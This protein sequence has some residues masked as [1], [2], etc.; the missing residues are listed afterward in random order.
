MNAWAHVPRRADEE[1]KR[2]TP[3]FGDGHDLERKLCG[4][5]L[6]SYGWISDT[7]E[8]PDNVPFFTRRHKLE[9]LK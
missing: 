3:L 1:D 8:V 6:F 9:A 2:K 4:V 5:R 7:R